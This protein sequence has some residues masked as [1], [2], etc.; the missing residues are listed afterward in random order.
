MLLKKKYTY[1]VYPLRGSGVRIN[2]SAVSHWGLL[3]LESG[4]VGASLYSWDFFSSYLQTAPIHHIH[5]IKCVMPCQKDL[6]F[7]MEQ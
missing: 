7:S 1:I 2:V 3:N 5:I 6:H 4:G